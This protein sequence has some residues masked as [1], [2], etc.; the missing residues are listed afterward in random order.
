M[1]VSWIQVLNDTYDKAAKYV[2][3]KDQ[4]GFVLLPIA[5]STQN[6]QIEIAI[7]LK[8]NFKSARKVEKVESVT[9]IP[10]TEDSGSR[11]N[12][13]APHPLCDKLCYIAGDYQLYCK[14]EK[15]QEQFNAYINQLENWVQNGAHEY[16][17][18]I[19]YY[20]KEKKM[21]K[22][23]L[24]SDILSL[25]EA[26]LLDPHFKIEGIVQEEAFVRFRIQD[27]DVPGTG[28]IWTNTSI[29]DNF[30]QYYL[31][32]F[33]SYDLDYISG[34]LIPCSF[35]QPSKIRHSGD[36]SKLISGNDSSGFTYRGRFATKEEAISIGYIPSQK[37]HNAL[38][39]LIE[40]QGY[41]RFGM[42][43]TTWNPE[44]KEIPDWLDS[45][46]FDLMY[47]DSDATTLDLGEDY[48][49]EINKAVRGK[50]AKI[51]NPSD[52]IVVMGLNAA[53]PGRLSV[54][55][56]QQMSGSKFLD[57]LLSWHLSC[58]WILNY[59][60]NKIGKNLP[61][62]PEPEDIVKAA[63]GVE[64]NNF[65]HVDDA[66]MQD[67][68]KRLIPCIIE[69]KRIPPDIVKAAFENACRPQAFSLY[70]RRKIVDIA[71]ALI[72]KKTQEKVKNK[73]GALNTMGLDRNIRNRDYLYGRLMAVAH[74]LE[75]DT[76]S[77]EERGKRE[78]NS[79]RYR[80]MVVKKPKQYW[81]VVEQRIQPYI[82][83]LDLGLQIK[84]DK[85]FQEI[86]T[87]FE[88][89]DF[90][91]SR[92]LDERFLLGYNCELSEL[93]KG[94]NTVNSVITGGNNHE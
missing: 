45:D 90:S 30:I 37:A 87:S 51:D 5:H 73:K 4:K 10:V 62:S 94:S 33:D 80:Y 60:K 3:I 11:S 1:I 2:G 63:Y 23:L 52:Q 82:K 49:E 17:K 31:S 13:I 58:N 44:E 24:E 67:T 68:L 74:K 70:N 85:E 41:R 28:E 38:R 91:N 6:A 71:C 61:M 25:N 72:N 78:T 8:G 15:A 75:Y 26:H 65:L 27:E 89:D 81:R 9:I 7:D 59:K 46:T 34:E 92:G 93:W 48:A 29:Y 76:F 50:Y 57:N 36:K 21:I 39:W 32:Q 86:Y 66:L 12:G 14:K 43:I 42:C 53:T 20:V 22:D 47:G 64:R 55:Y 16:V 88:N 18:A 77:D 19:Y 84:Y 83:K 40:R 79:D 35:K 56:Y 69:G 54:T